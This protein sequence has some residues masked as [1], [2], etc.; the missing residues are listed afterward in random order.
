MPHTP[1]P[2]PTKAELYAMLNEAVRNTGA[3]RAEPKPKGG[4][5]RAAKRSS[6]HKAAPAKPS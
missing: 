3:Q 2:K 1:P 4:S 6:G 5:P